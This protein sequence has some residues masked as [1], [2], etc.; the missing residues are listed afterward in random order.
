MIGEI[1]KLKNFSDQEP[2]EEIKMSFEES[3]GVEVECD[4]CGRLHYSTFWQDGLSDKEILK[5]EAYQQENNYRC[6]YHNFSSVSFG[7]YDGN[8]VVLKCPCH[9]LRKIEENWW[10]NRTRVLSYLEARYE[11]RGKI[12]REEEEQLKNTLEIKDSE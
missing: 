2:S 11:S 8:K 9:F 7:Y 5:S 6:Y 10:N 4:M 3:G 1:K 12:V